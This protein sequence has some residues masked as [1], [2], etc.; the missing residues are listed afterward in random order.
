MGRRKAF[1]DVA[2]NLGRSGKNCNAIAR[3][4]STIN[5]TINATTFHNIL[6]YFLYA[7]FSEDRR[8]ASVI[9]LAPGVECLTVDRE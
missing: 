9:A 4:M 2:L 7:I 6:M 3:A 8:T 5:F 1:R